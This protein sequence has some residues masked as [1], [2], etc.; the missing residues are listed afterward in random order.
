MNYRT[1]CYW[2]QDESSVL[3]FELCFSTGLFIS[4][5]D[6]IRLNDGIF[7]IGEPSPVLFLGEA[8]SNVSARNSLMYEEEIKCMMKIMGLC[9]GWLE[10]PFNQLTPLKSNLFCLSCFAFLSLKTVKTVVCASFNY[11]EHWKACA[12]SDHT[13]LESSAQYPTPSKYTSSM[14]DRSNNY[15]RCYYY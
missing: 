11:R 10:P 8:V 9:I 7:C 2:P 4:W 12:P 5:L 1:S 3:S 14:T 15:R 6:C 13:R